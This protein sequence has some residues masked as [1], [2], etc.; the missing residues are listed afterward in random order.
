MAWAAIKIT[1]CLSIF[2]TPTRYG[3]PLQSPAIEFNFLLLIIIQNLPAKSAATKN[4][5]KNVTWTDR[6]NKF[7]WGVRRRCTVQF[8]SGFGFRF[9]S[10]QAVLRFSV[11]LIRL[12]SPRSSCLGGS[13]AH[14]TNSTTTTKINIYFDSFQF[15]GALNPPNNMNT[16]V[17]YR[18]CSHT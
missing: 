1:R 13:S 14:L 7:A 18:I 10:C 8:Q 2:G 16:L 4:T 12:C 17:L 3:F 5:Q 15:C 11:K 9:L 6:R